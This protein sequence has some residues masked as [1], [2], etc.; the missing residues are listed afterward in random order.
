MADLANDHAGAVV[1]LLQGAG[2][3]VYDAR[4]PDS[5]TLPYVVL[6]AEP[7]LLQRSALAAT[8]GWLDW[9]FQVTAVGKERSQAAWAAQ[10]ARAALVDVA[11]T[12]TGRTCS[13]ILQDSSQPITRDDDIT[14]PVFYVAAGYRLLSVPS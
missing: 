12:V 4:V 3:T 1:A 14:P 11:P 9:P 7:G 13:P 5:P 8:S 6:Y 2:L 10:K